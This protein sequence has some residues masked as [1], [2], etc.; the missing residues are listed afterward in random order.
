MVKDIYSIECETCH[1]YNISLVKCESCWK[2]EIKQKI[3]KEI[4]RFRKLR[5]YRSKSCQLLLKQLEKT[6][7]EK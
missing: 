5:L 4:K 3:I 2:K 1:S 7:G 6:L